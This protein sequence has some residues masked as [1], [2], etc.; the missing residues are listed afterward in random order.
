MIVKGKQT[1]MRRPVKQGERHPWFRPGRNYAI[2]PGLGQRQ[3]TRIAINTIEAGRLGDITFN[4]VRAE[5]FR[6]TIEYKAF[7]VRTYDAAW[8]VREENRLERTVTDEELAGRFDTRHADTAVWI[9]GFELDRSH[10]PRLLAPTAR[11]E[12]DGDEYG[13][14]DNPTRSL[15][16]EPE[17]VDASIL[18]KFAEDAAMRWR[19]LPGSREEHLRRR[20]RSLR[21]RLRQAALNAGRAGVDITRQLDSIEHHIRMLEQ[22][23]K[24]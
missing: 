12:R 6:T 14:T 4:D 3:I 7:W 24:A 9:V 1:V 5:G 19:G 20:E 8:V 18:A 15:R 23:R 10:R 21:I 16:D 22:Q 13:Y 2:Q 11:G 17:A